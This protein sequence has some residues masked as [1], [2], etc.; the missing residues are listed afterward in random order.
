[1]SD[2]LSWNNLSQGE[3]ETFID[4]AKK[5]ASLGAVAG[6]FNGG[7]ISTD[8]TMATGKKFKADADAI[9]A[10]DII[11]PQTKTISVMHTLSGNTTRSIFIADETYQLIAFSFASQTVYSGGVLDLRKATGSTLISAATSMLDAPIPMPSVSEGVLNGVMSGTV[12]NIQLAVGDRIGV[13][14]TSTAGINNANG[15]GITFTLTFK[16][17]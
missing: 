1:M 3:K 17:I 2:S 8:T 12:A 6:T 10:A 16:R 11:I 9:L 4:S 7:T 13:Y 15:N 14:V 5:I